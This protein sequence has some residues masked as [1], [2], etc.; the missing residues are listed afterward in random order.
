MRESGAPPPGLDTAAKVFESAIEQSDI[1]THDVETSTD[2][3]HQQ[4]PSPA[5]PH[6]ANST[7]CR[8]LNL[9]QT[10]TQFAMPTSSSL[11]NQ[12]PSSR[13]RSSRGSLS[14]QTAWNVHG[15]Q[16]AG[17]YDPAASAASMPSL[18]VSLS[19]PEV[20]THSPSQMPSPALAVPS[21][22]RPAQSPR[23]HF[24]SPPPRAARSPAAAFPSPQLR[25][26][27]SLTS[28]LSKQRSSLPPRSFERS[29]QTTAAQEAAT[30][31]AN[32]S[33]VTE[34]H[35][36]EGSDG[37]P[38]EIRVHLPNGFPGRMPAGFRMPAGRMPGIS[39][40][41]VAAPPRAG[42]H[43]SALSADATTE[44]SPNATLGQSSNLQR[45]ERIERARSANSINREL[46]IDRDEIAAS[47]TLSSKIHQAGA[48]AAG[49]APS[50]LSNPIISQAREKLRVQSF[51]FGIASHK[52]DSSGMHELARRPSRP[53]SRPEASS[54]PPAWRA[55]QS[56][57]T[58]TSR[59]LE[60]SLLVHHPTASQHDATARHDA[61]PVS[62]DLSVD[63]T[64]FTDQSTLSSPQ[65]QGARPATRADAQ[66]ALREAA[67][68]DGSGEKAGSEPRQA[69]QNAPDP[70]QTASPAVPRIRRAG[71]FGSKERGDTSASTDGAAA[72]MS[73]AAAVP[74]PPPRRHRT[75]PT[76][77][78]VGEVPAVVPLQ[79]SAASSEAACSSPADTA[80]D[81]AVTLPELGIPSS[82]LHAPPRRALASPGASQRKNSFSRAAKRLQPSAVEPP[83][84]RASS[85]DWLAQ[86]DQDTDWGKADHPNGGLV[87]TSCDTAAKALA[88]LDKMGQ[89]FAKLDALKGEKAGAIAE[90]PIGG[91]SAAQAEVETKALQRTLPRLSSLYDTFPATFEKAEAE[92]EAEAKAKAEAE[93]KEKAEAE[94]AEEAPPPPP[95]RSRSLAAKPMADSRQRYVGHAADCLGSSSV[96]DLS[97]RFSSG[98]SEASA[99]AMPASAAQLS[100]HAFGATTPR[101][102]KLVIRRFSPPD[103]MARPTLADLMRKFEPVSAGLPSSRSPR[104]ELS[105]SRRHVAHAAEVQVKVAK[106]RTLYFGKGSEAE[107]LTNRPRADQGEEPALEHTKAKALA[108]VSQAAALQAVP[109]DA[110]VGA[111]LAMSDTALCAASPPGFAAKRNSSMAM[112]R[113]Q[114]LNK[115]RALEDE[116]SSSRR[117]KPGSLWRE[118][119]A[120][121]PASSA[122]AAVAVTAGEP[123]PL[124][125]DGV[126]TA[127]D[128]LRAR[129]GA[130]TDAEPRVAEAAARVSQPTQNAAAVRRARAARRTLTESASFASAAAPA[131]APAAAAAAPAPVNPASAAPAE[132][133][134][135]APDE[136][137]LASG[138]PAAGSLA[139]AAGRA[140]GP[141]TQLAWSMRDSLGEQALPQ[142][143]DTPRCASNSSTTP[144]VSPTAWLPAEAAPV[145]VSPTNGILAAAAASSSKASGRLK[146]ATSFASSKGWE[147][148]RAARKA[149]STAAPT[150]PRDAATPQRKPSRLYSLLRRAYPKG[151]KAAPGRLSPDLSTLMT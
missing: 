15:T 76:E 96:S 150:T 120:P 79:A 20:P 19:F 132:Q 61:T 102:P 64:V 101:A 138:H 66:P 65:L 32:G 72:S 147:L 123:L 149:S 113:Q 140:N 48:A 90:A 116:E 97:R 83:R 62:R 57:M 87:G 33:I 21:P 137:Q 11:T 75:K 134:H 94:A 31:A 8:T 142:Q 53:I 28:S 16:D 35:V 46:S 110:P 104:L 115:L 126:T 18:G 95:R 36:V 151:T 130:A 13:R 50:F 98:V 29:K 125:G 114:Q 60:N 63:G 92:V 73:A 43:L 143:G 27:E 44:L 88:A 56:G 103:E 41:S 144:V 51:N 30:A 52:R 45:K 22:P 81:T 70:M 23:L 55:A 86:L 111:P 17:A 34:I 47:P 127:A 7:H 129:P 9:S 124:H 99:D 78:A 77:V 49:A 5:R 58:A 117:G 91:G 148:L 12:L 39:P 118:T 108:A 69:T 54:V 139:A 135:S 82:L 37:V 10:E 146:T 93:T 74:P 100:A 42:S 59:D 109:V 2:E 107:S 4:P 84:Q 105:G 67:T 85:A 25:G 133:P 89:T 136:P 122:A 68:R 131:P 6:H 141:A 128:V 26:S 119:V 80:P 145:S 112:N 40:A 1:A 71:T 3:V 24:P 106:P 14:L 121:P 38:Q